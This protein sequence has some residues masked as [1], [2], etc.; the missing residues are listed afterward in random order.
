MTSKLTVLPPANLISTIGF[1]PDATHNDFVDDFRA[2]LPTGAAPVPAPGPRPLPDAAFD[3]WALLATLLAAYRDHPE[4]T[5]LAR[6]R[7]LVRD[8]Q[9]RLHLAPFDHLEEASAV[10]RHL[11]A[12]GTRSPHLDAVLARLEST[13]AAS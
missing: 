12:I 1:R 10:L 3:R 8:P 4:I 13:K 9:L 11:A 6:A 5:R 7:H 2:G